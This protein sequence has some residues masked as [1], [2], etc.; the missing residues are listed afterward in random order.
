MSLSDLSQEYGKKVQT[1]LNTMQTV[2]SKTFTN[3]LVKLSENCK[4]NRDAFG[5]IMNANPPY[6][7]QIAD[8]YDVLKSANLSLARYGGDVDLY[9]IHEI[10]LD[11][12]RLHDKLA[13]AMNPDVFLSLAGTY[14]TN[15]FAEKVAV[16]SAL[17][18]DDDNKYNG[19]LQYFDCKGTLRKI[20]AY[21]KTDREVM[22]LVRV[23]GHDIN[24]TSEIS[25]QQKKLSLTIGTTLLDFP[26]ELSEVGQNILIVWIGEII[27]FMNFPELL[28]YYDCTP[29]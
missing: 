18:I 7:D 22:R 13:Q 17:E 26:N 23:T 1:F 14:L 9:I 4:E 27:K 19:D 10:L 16:E 6:Q 21:L 11:I 3:I 29:S 28:Q 5:I 24:K 2:D 8:F 12:K 25:V 15:C 20:I